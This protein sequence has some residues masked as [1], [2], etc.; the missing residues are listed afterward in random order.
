VGV[1][2][3]YSRARQVKGLCGLLTCAQHSR[4]LTRCGGGRGEGCVLLHKLSRAGWVLRV[5]QHS[6]MRVR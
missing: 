4:W 1:L 3:S 2:Q 6:S 5:W